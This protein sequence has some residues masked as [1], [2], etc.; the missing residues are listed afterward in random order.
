VLDSGRDGLTG[1]RTMSSTARL[2]RPGGDEQGRSASP[3]SGSGVLRDRYHREL[4][5][6]NVLRLGI[7]YLAPLV[8]LTAYFDVQYRELSSSGRLL[9]LESVA[10]HH[11]NV[12]DLFLRERVV[13]LVNLID[14]PR[15]PLPPSSAQ[16]EGVLQR[17]RRESGTFVDVGFIDGNGVQQA[18]SGPFPFLEKRDYSAQSWFLTLVGGRER[19][20]VTDSYLGFRNRPHLTIAVSRAQAG[21]TAMLKVA[22]DPDEVYRQID[23]LTG[24]ENLDVSIVNRAGRY[25]LVPSHLGHPLEASSL[26]PPPEPRLGIHH[27]RTGGR[28]VSYAYVWLRTA[29]W[30]VIVRDPAGTARAGLGTA[31]SRITLLGLSV[32]LILVVLSVIVIRAKRLVELQIEREL[33]QAQFE[34]AARLASVGEL[35]AGIAHEINNPLAIISEE[36]GLIRDLMNPEMR[37]G[38]TF[39]DLRPHLDTIEEAV[40]RC[41]DITR[42]LLSFVR[43]TDI[44]VRP[45]D[46]TQLLDELID[47]FWVREMEVANIEVVRRYADERLEVVTDGNQLKQ[48]LLN[49]LNNAADAI[50][51]PGRIT[52]TTARAGDE[53]SVGIADTG[54]G[55]SR[56]E[57]GRIFLPFF[58]TKEVGKGTGLGLSVSLGIVRSLGGQILVESLPGKGSLFT[59]LLPS[60]VPG[61]TSRAGRS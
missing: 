12:L 6:R 45:H 49:I 10:E 19:F 61:R 43:K 52:I 53:I 59:V 34:H 31:G 46:L 13:N 42:K 57:M 40:F 11:A 24:S 21:G 4:L 26:M 23:S 14:D 44:Q 41:R 9:H 38:T 1:A 15:L 56:E 2:R 20:V 28:E 36:A 32:A 25:Q 39:S 54:K 18:Y 17:L 3:A 60:G 30:A 48:V 5:G 33:T 35:S 50:R 37:A 51:P 55:I 27:G 16:L 8:L 29:P 47:G 58:T 7:T 22:L